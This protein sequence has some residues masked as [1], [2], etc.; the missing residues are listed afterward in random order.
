[1]ILTCQK[2]I[3]IMRNKHFKKYHV[4]FR[5]EETTTTTTTTTT[6]TPTTPAATTPTTPAPTN[7]VTA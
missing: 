4:Y 7:P 2:Y 6:P 1:M 5:C 3:F